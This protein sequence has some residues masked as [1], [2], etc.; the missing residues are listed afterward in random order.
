MCL[1]SNWKDLVTF[2]G[3]HE[4][5]GTECPSEH[6]VLA[7]VNPEFTVASGGDGSCHYRGKISESGGDGFRARAVVNKQDKFYSSY[8][9]SASKCL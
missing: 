7:F 1:E 5:A 4:A 3:G 8:L 6:K 2:A 9:D